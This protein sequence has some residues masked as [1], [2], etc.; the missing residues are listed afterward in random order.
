MNHHQYHQD[1]Q[2][3]IQIDITV[4]DVAGDGSVRKSDDSPDNDRYRGDGDR[5]DT[6]IDYVDKTPTQTTTKESEYKRYFFNR[7]IT[8]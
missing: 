4:V 1:H 5:M 7:G 3:K 2:D 8:K 6:Y